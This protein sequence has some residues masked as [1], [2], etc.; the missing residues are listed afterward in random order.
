M[1]ISPDVLTYTTI[2]GVAPPLQSFTITNTGGNGLTWSAGP[3]SQLWLTL[4][5]TSGS[6]NAGAISIIPMHIDVQGLASGVYTATVVITPSVGQ[7]Q[8]VSVT[9]SVN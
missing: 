4:D 5:L 9:L 2:T 7:A 1:Q 6:D 3:P 8:A